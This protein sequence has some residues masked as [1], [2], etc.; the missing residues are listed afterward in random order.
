MLYVSFTT[1][2]CFLAAAEPDDNEGEESYSAAADDDKE[3]EPIDEEEL[4]GLEEDLK[5]PATRRKSKTPPRNTAPAEDEITVLARGMT[6][7]EPTNEW[8]SPNWS[9][10]YIIY[11][12]KDEEQPLRHM[13]VDIMMPGVP[14]NFIRKMEVLSCGK[15]L[16]V[17]VG[18]PRWFFETTYLTRVMG[19]NFHAQHAAVDNFE[20]NV[21]QPVRRKFK[22]NNPWI[23]SSPCIVN[24]PEKC[25]VGDAQWSRGYFRTANAPDPG[26]M[27]QYTWITFVMLKTTKTFELRNNGA[28]AGA[29]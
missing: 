29:M 28:A 17:Q 15:K 21:V 6:I 13:H 24:L 8:S 9:F 14:E 16:S 10:P 18:T 20:E 1:Q 23:E 4:E 27:I 25:H 12:Y 11:A 2:N 22:E 5:M 26:G 7:S 19:N 3:E